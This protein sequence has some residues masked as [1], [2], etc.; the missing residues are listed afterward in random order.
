M[1]TYQMFN[2]FSRWDYF[3]HL[4]SKHNTIQFISINFISHISYNLIQMLSYIQQ[5]I[6]MIPHQFIRCLLLLPI[7][8]RIHLIV[9]YIHYLKQLSESAINSSWEQKIVCHLSLFNRKTELTFFSNDLCSL[10]SYKLYLSLYFH[11]KYAF[12]MQIS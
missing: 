3:I 7:L 12:M 4:T 9:I 10:Y 11:L 5:G 6:L 8:K 2:S 1:M